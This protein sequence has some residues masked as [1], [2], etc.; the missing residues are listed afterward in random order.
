MQKTLSNSSKF[1]SSSICFLLIFLWIMNDH[2]LKPEFHNKITGKLSD[3]TGLIVFPFFLTA[4]SFIACYGLVKELNLFIFANLGV[5]IL[6]SIINWSQD[7]NNWI[8]ANFFG[9]Q[10]GTADKTDLLCVPVCLLANFY[11]YKKYSAKE[12]LVSPKRKSLHI[13]AI[14]LSALAFINTSVPDKKI[15]SEILYPIIL[16]RPDR[17]DIYNINDE[18]Y[19]I[20]YT[21]GSFKEFS[22]HLYDEKENLTYK[23]SLQPS[24]VERRL[25]ERIN[26]YYYIYSANLLLAEGY[27]RLTIIGSKNHDW[28][29]KAPSE[30]FNLIK[31]NK[32]AMLNLSCTSFRWIGFQ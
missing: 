30:I 32:C 11:F 1:L 5:T 17:G 24:Q 22:I 6:F 18:V 26:K 14:I 3:I 15:E 19:F 13:I 4:I 31:E 9:N 29:N 10:N 27:N 23:I 28:K 7:W 20:W 21:D 2:L 8:Y 25:D 12:I 16:V